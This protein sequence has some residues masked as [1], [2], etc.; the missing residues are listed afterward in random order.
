MRILKS[1][2]P[3]PSQGTEIDYTSKNYTCHIYTRFCWFTTT[4]RIPLP[5]Y[6]IPKLWLSVSGLVLKLDIEQPLYIGSLSQGAGVRVTLHEQGTMPFPYEEGF[7]VNPGM[8]T[9]VG[10]RKVQ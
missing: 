7:N 1:S 9:Y 5:E 6:W 4:F 10:L 3:G 8:S 2:K